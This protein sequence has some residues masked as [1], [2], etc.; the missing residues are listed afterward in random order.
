MPEYVDQNIYN[1]QKVWG[2]KGNEDFFSNTRSKPEHLY[3]SEKFFLPE[4]LVKSKTVLD[5]GCACGDFSAIFKEYNPSID[6]IGIDIIERFIAIAKK[7]YPQSRFEHSD[8][9]HLNF[10]DN[11]ID[12]VH[13]SGILHLNSRY[14]DIVR[15]MYRV[16]RTH[17]LCD[18]RLTKGEDMLGEMDVNL[19][20]QQDQVQTLP[21]YVLNVDAHL[22]FL[23]SLTPAP[24]RIEIKGYAHPPSK[25]ARIAIDEILMAFFLIT[26]GN[27]SQPTTIDINLNA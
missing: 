23:K 6:Y 7:R 15:Q 22:E 24:S 11:S 25:A 16:A 14:Q 4:V 20:G 1:E 9:I 27:G 12:L 21:Y 2:L 10:D 26:K 5:V 17:V 3:R 18:F 19:Q 13:S 8:G